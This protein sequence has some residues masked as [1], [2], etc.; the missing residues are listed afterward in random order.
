MNE[1][2][3]SVQ[4]DQ[5]AAVRRELEDFYREGK[6]P[7]DCGITPPELVELIEGPYPLTPGHALELGCGTGTNAVYLA[8]HGWRVA[9]V[10]LV[11]RAVLQAREKS[12]AAGVDVTVLSGDATRLDE[13]GLPGPYDLFF[14]LSCF[15][16]IPPHRR[17]AYA[18]GLTAR[19]A[20]GA[21]L[22]M[23]GYGP[24]AWDDPISGVTADELRERFT[25][26]RLTDETPGTNPVPTAWFTLQRTAAAE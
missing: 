7:W 23:F 22:L 16:G 17:D 18:A 20:P 19:A 3:T 24:D 6:P 8:L 5:E 11:E 14:D 10:D 9:A 1:T 4:L 26:W 21:R 25:G 15:C 13:I 12:A 2:R